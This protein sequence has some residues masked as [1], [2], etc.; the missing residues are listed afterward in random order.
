MRLIKKLVT[1]S[2][3]TVRIVKGLPK[4]GEE[5]P[6]GFILSEFTEDINN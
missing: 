4:L 3:E 1:V 5:I 6:T 2:V